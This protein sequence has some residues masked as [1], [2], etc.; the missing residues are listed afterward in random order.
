MLQTFG[1]SVGKESLK[2]LLDTLAAKQVARLKA[3]EAGLE[4]DVLEKALERPLVVRYTRKEVS[5]WQKATGR[6]DV[7]VAT[8]V[9]GANVEFRKEYRNKLDLMDPTILDVT[10]I[11]T[12][13][14]SVPV[15][16]C[17]EPLPEGVATGW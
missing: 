16:S 11:R 10:K 1:L 4:Q 9:G 3:N 2:L 6:R 15:D 12:R 5:H 17:S 13:A 8:L 7:F 14:R